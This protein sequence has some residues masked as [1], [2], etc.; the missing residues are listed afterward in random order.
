M[1]GMITRLWR[2]SGRSMGPGGVVRPAGARAVLA[3]SVV[4]GKV[5]ASDDFLLKT[6]AVSGL[7][8]R[9]GRERAAP[10]PGMSSI[11]TSSRCVERCARGCSRGTAGGRPLLA[12]QQSAPLY[13]LNWIGVL[14]PYWDAL[15]WIAILK[16]ILYALGTFLL[17]RAL[18]LADA[19]R[20]RRSRL[21]VW[22]H[23]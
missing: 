3:P 16:L 2:L 7:A 19:R 15:V 6:P 4:G 9:R 18:G 5:L 23:A 21:R 1:S 17:C 12:A 13:P 20:A 8:E 14:F 22:H 11:P 10:G